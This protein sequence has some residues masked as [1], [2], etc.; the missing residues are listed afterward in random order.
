MTVVS[1]FWN[2]VITHVTAIVMAIAAA[3]AVVIGFLGLMTWHYE[4]HGRA[5]FDVARRVM[6]AVYDMR[7]ESSGKPQHFFNEIQLTPTA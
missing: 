6:R 5:D 7:N 3:G 2:T 4:L 1:A